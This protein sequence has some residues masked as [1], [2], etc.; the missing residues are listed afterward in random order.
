MAP[1]TKRSAPQMRST[2]RAEQRHGRGILV[3]ALTLAPLLFIA[4]GIWQIERRGEKLALIA[5]V[6]ARVSAAP[7][8]APGPDEWPG[9]SA[10]DAAYRHIVAHGTFEND[11]ETLVQAVTDLGA[12]YWVLTPL[13]TEQGWTVLVNRGFVAPER[14]ARA[15]R[16]AGEPRGSVAITGLLRITEPKGAFLRTNDPVAGRWYSRDV[17]AIGKAKGLVELAP[18]FIDAAA[19]PEGD[20]QPVGGLTVVRFYNHH[21]E[22]ALTWFAL[23]ALSI[24]G[25]FLVRWAER[26]EAA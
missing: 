5:A 8:P 2:V 12:G 4:L 26:L 25:L 15:V 23:A 9:I 17:A 19:T 18:Y 21:L 7:T 22:Y 14:Q 11:R 6:N 3:A 10:A 20:G 16:K 24:V 13:R 1:A